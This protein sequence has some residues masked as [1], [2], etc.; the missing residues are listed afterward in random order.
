MAKTNTHTI[1]RLFKSYHREQLKAE[2]NVHLPCN[3]VE[4]PKNVYNRN[5]LKRQITEEY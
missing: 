4:I 1:Q 2:G 5:K 3:K